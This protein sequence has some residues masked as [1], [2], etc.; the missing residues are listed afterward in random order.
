MLL[1]LLILLHQFP[2]LADIVG[3]EASAIVEIMVKRTGSVRR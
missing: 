1:E 3:V 2:F